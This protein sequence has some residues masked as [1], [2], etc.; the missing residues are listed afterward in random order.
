MAWDSAT[1]TGS[2]FV[3][4]PF[5]LSFPVW[6]LL[7]AGWFLLVILW[8]S[9]AEPGLV[10]KTLGF[11]LAAIGKPS[12]FQSRHG[13]A[14]CWPA[15][16]PGG[17]AAF[18]YPEFPARFSQPLSGGVR[19]CCRPSYHT[20]PDSGPLSS[21]RGVFSPRYV[22]LT[23]VF[24]LAGARPPDALCN[25]EPKPSRQWLEILVSLPPCFWCPEMFEM[26]FFS[27]H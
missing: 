11:L 12:H 27:R 5:A 6:H 13:F 2:V 18:L 14:W 9:R 3:C 10:L 23:S 20:G 1:L 4:L 25:L 24:S 16:R 7:S 8:L 15:E 17:W 21:H 26:F 22:P 19:L